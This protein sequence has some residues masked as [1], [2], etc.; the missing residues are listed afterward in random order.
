MSDQSGVVVDRPTMQ[1]VE[2]VVDLWVDLARG[3]RRHGSHLVAAENRGRIRE[4]ISRQIA[5][6]EVHVARSDGSIVGFVMYT[7]EGSTFQRNVER[8]VVQN[9]YVAPSYRNQ[10]VGTRLLETAEQALRE[11]GAEVLG[12]E[13][14]AR[15]EAARRFYER[16]G[17]DTHR[18]VL[19]KST[20]SD[21]S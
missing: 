1:D 14:M 6:S 3:Q 18:L 9:L 10:G 4:S 13:V 17:Y 21:T 11:S 16:H 20:E 5:L 12:L 2:A 19:E 8:G 7:L 15:N